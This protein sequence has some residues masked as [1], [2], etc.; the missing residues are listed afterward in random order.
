MNRSL[1]SAQMRDT[2]GDRIVAT[3]RAWLR[4]RSV[5]RAIGA[6]L[7][8][9]LLCLAGFFLVAPFYWLFISAVKPKDQLFVIPPV[10][11]PREFVWR[12][13]LDVWTVA[14]FGRYL[15]NTV[16]I[17]SLSVIGHVLVAAVVG[18]GFAVGRFRGRD[19][20]FVVVLATMMIPPQVTLVPLFV[21]FR[22]LGWLNT[23]LPLVVPTFFGVGGAFYIFLTRQF[24]L[25]IPVELEE[26]ARIDGA[27]TLRILWSVYVPLSVPVLTTVAIFAFVHSW[28]DFF[29]PL[30]YLTRQSSWTLVLGLA[31]LQDPS[32]WVDYRQQMAGALLVSLPVVIIFLFAQRYYTKGIAMT[33]I[34]G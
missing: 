2:S 34:T 5:R 12:A 1:P 25:T 7:T 20:W 28:N 26:A 30:I 33:G 6:T 18:Y 21:I 11:W 31:A 9:L 27:S 24:F 8:L 13:F 10:Y 19:F 23:I 15:L 29:G 4:R 14:P 32:G 3:A 22:H 16:R 17:A